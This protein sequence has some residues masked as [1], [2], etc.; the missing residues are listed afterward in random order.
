MP[1]YSVSGKVKPK[2]PHILFYAVKHSHSSHWSKLKLVMKIKC[3][4]DRTL[5]LAWE[6]YSFMNTAQTYANIKISRIIALLQRSELIGL[7][8]PLTKSPHY[9]KIILMLIS[10]CLLI[11]LHSFWKSSKQYF[12]WYWNVALSK[13]P[14][15]CRNSI[16]TL[17][18]KNTLKGKSSSKEKFMASKLV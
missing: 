17:K 10:S 1:S 4:H 16:L 11:N 12:P 15:S 5:I 2:N 6:Q 7:I 3:P 18:G 8:W 14:C 9:L 13:C